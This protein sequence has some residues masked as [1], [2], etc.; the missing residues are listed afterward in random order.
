MEYIFIHAK[1]NVVTENN[2]GMQN[3][4]EKKIKCKEIAL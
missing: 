2:D 4:K 3:S 1:N